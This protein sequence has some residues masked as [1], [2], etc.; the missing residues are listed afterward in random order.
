MRG[1][2]PDERIRTPMAW[3]GA[4]P[5]HGFSG[6]DGLEVEPWEAFADGVE[7]ANVAAQAADPGSIRSHYQALIELRAAHPALRSAEIIPV[8]SSTP[9]VY[10][11]LRHDPASG[12]VIAVISNLTDAALPDA[13]LR[14]AASP[15][16]GTPT[17]T[18]L[19]GDASVPAPP[20]ID[21]AGGFEAWRTGPLPAHGDLIVQLSP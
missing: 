11:Q 4:A 19:L 10:A 2:K 3:D 13:T 18:G 20:R 15:L 21:G 8:A 7:T 9:G 16:C 1:R 17:A 14:V 12:E 5:N 6:P